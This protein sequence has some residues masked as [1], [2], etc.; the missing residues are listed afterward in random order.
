M[1]K[2]KYANLSGPTVAKLLKCN[3]KTAYK[4][5]KQIVIN[6]KREITL[7]DI[8][9]LIYEYKSRHKQLNF[10]SYLSL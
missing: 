4:Y 3:R 1:N 7:E 9:N 6:S 2:G 5:L 10:D 8:G